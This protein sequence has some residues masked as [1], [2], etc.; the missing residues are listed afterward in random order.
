M[1][2]RNREHLVRWIPRVAEIMTLDDRL[3]LVRRWQ[4]RFVTGEDRIYAMFA[5]EGRPIGSVGFHDRVG[6]RSLE[7]GY[8]ID[9]EHEGRG[10]VT[11]AVAALVR[12]G[13]EVHDVVRLEIRCEPDN[14]RS[15]AVPARL[16]FTHETTLRRRAIGHEGALVDLMVW[17]RYA[18]DPA[19]G[20]RAPMR[21]WDGLGRRLL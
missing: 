9:A 6:P 17:A 19:G 20:E 14:V 2:V 21:A 12:V 1:S 4:Q 16:G 11:E 8:W 15:A 5:A 3:A 18:E 7:I 13:F 10:Y